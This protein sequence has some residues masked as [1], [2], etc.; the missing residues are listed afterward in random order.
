MRSLIHVLTLEL[1]G[2]SMVLEDLPRT[3]I[4][5][6]GLSDWAGYA[7]R[8]TG[9]FDYS[10]TYFHMTPRLDIC[11]PDEEWFAKLDFLIASDVFEHVFAPVSDA[12]AGAFNVLRPGGLFVMTAPYD[13]RPTTTEHYPIG[14]WLQTMEFD[15]EFVVV[16][17]DPSGVFRLD[18]EP[19]FHGG[20]GSTLE[21]RMFSLSDLVALMHEAGFEDVKVH[22]QGWAPFGVFP[23][24]PWGLPITGRR[25]VQRTTSVTPLSGRIPPKSSSRQEIF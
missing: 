22:D 23:P 8:L 6:G 4:R 21:M 9:R 5:G 7:G 2:K 19:V 25:P 13:D 12:F 3:A 20:P 1:L 15:G 11:Q 10:N 18:A 17:R 16:H 24:H 14:A